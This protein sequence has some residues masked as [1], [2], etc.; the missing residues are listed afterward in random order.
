MPPAVAAWSLNRWTTREVPKCDLI[1]VN[2]KKIH[3]YPY[4]SIRIEILIYAVLLTVAVFESG[5]TE[6]SNFPIFF[7]DISILFFLI[8]Y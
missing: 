1:F 5:I 7:C 6:Y 3:I 8:I 4:I 2:L